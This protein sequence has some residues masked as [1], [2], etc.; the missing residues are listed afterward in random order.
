VRRSLALALLAIVAL[1]AVGL[2]L[3]Q[4]RIAR[5][6]DGRVFAVEAVP[7]RSVA[8]VFGAS[9]GSRVLRDRVATGA[10]LYHAHKVKH[11]LLTG[12]NRAS[13]Y[14]EPR[15]MKRMAIESG[16]PASALVLDYAG[17]HTYDSCARARSIFQLDS[18]V[19]VTQGFHLPRALYLCERL[20]VSG[21]VG[22]AADRQTSP[23]GWLWAVRE[24]FADVKAW[25]DV[26]VRHPSV[27][28]G[29]ALPIYD[30]PPATAAAPPP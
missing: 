20:G 15:A 19:L 14:D 4:T 25:Y 28:G 30:E 12:D 6:A 2:A 18:P 23:R 22:V 26:H 13:S 8:I 10:A 9:V 16:V 3:I 24:L 27:V 21:A 17:R 5:A 11:L 1:A 29:P 7:E